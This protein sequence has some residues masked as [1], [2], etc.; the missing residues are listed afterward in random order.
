MYSL[1]AAFFCA[2]FGVLNHWEPCR[3]QR[4]GFF[5]WFE[6]NKKT[7]LFHVMAKFHAGFRLKDPTR[8]SAEKAKLQ[9][10]IRQYMGPC[11]L[12]CD[13]IRGRIIRNPL[14]LQTWIHSKTIQNALLRNHTYCIEN[15]KKKEIPG[16]PQ[17]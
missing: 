10:R 13:L 8:I 12:L 3:S 4:P 11:R 16:N 9:K 1:V 17:T 14:R 7:T 5:A 15:E 2:S 6:M